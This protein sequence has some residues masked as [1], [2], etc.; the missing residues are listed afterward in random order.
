MRLS[1][2]LQN[3]REKITEAQERFHRPPGSVQLLA[4]S[5]K[6]SPE[7]I[8]EAFVEGQLLFGENY[9]QEALPKISILKD[10]NIQWHFIGGIQSNKTR[11]IAENFSWV[12]SVSQVKIAERLNTQRPGNL[13]PLN[14]CIQVNVDEESSKDGIMIDEIWPLA[15]KLITFPALKFRG[16]MTLPKPEV[17]FEKQRVPF[18]KLFQAFQKLQSV[19]FAVDTLSMGTSDDYIAAISEGA[20]MVRIGTAIF[21][22][23][24]RR[25]K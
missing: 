23:R 7:K 22:E 19:G 10:K 14:V 4:V 2:N 24:K 17:C 1:F 21:G 12:H 3:L 16:L 6:Q 15:E 11:A 9:L 8:S 20:T 18:Q 5:K 13:P 25:F